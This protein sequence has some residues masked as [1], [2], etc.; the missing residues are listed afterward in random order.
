MVTRLTHEA[1]QYSKLFYI[2]TM[3]EGL[4]ELCGFIQLM[5]YKTTTMHALCGI[6]A[7]QARRLGDTAE[8]FLVSTFL[9]HSCGGIAIAN[10]DLGA[11]GNRL[12]MKLKGKKSLNVEPNTKD[13]HDDNNNYVNDF[14]SIQKHIDLESPIMLQ[15]NV[16]ARPVEYNES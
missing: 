6:L 3:A 16:S 5:R 13:N 11:N 12:L 9:I 14:R 2:I 1:L 8:T 7:E 15:D 4:S 10:S